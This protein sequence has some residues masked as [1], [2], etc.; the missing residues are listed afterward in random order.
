MIT[1][2]FP[3]FIS[4]VIKMRILD[5]DAT[6]LAVK[7]RTKEISSLEAVDTY[8]AHLEQINNKVNCMV[9]D[10]FDE[11]RQEAKTYDTGGHYSGHLCGVPFSAKESF[12]IAGMGTTCGLIS[13]K[14]RTAAKDAEA[15]GLLRG[16]GAIFLCKT[17]TPALCFCQETDNKLYGRT[18]NPWDLS[19]TAGGSSGGEG[20]LIAVGGVACGLGADI[21]GSIRFPSHFNGIIG[22]K[23]GAMQV[24]Y[25]GLWP[26]FDNPWQLSMLGIGAMAKSVADA[27]LVNQILSSSTTKQQEPEL[28]AICIPYPMERYPMGE[29]TA[30]L[31][32]QIRDDLSSNM[33]VTTDE[34]PLFEQAALY[35]QLLMS[36]DGGKGVTE[37]AFAEDGS[38]ALLEYLKEVTLGRSDIHRYLSWALIGAGLFK[39]NAAKTQSLYRE[40]AAGREVVDRFLSN[41]VLILPVYHSAAPKH[42]QLYREIFSIR[43]T[44]LKYMPYVAYPNLWGLPSLTIPVGT[45]RQGMPIAVQL[46]GRTG[47][48][49]S[50]FQLGKLLEGSYGGYKRCTLHDSAL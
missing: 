16:E 38:I 3:D 1:G 4:E 10:R 2:R 48:E 43:K 37:A 50:L 45:D 14:D 6:S 24:P 20:A 28:A 34:P 31:I 13:H 26:E 8:I 9:E 17:N 44:F 29:E 15:V 33:T 46:V 42:G 39:P 35:W 49:A 19:R 36:V 22:F 5:L 21:G 32:A 11:A 23:S 7:I 41:R 30:G 40:L 47:Q 27:Q 18:N 25:T 12:D